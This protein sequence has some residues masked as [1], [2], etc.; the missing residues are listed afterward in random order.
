VSAS[1]NVAIL[2]A[3]G[4]VGQEMLK[5]LMTR[6]FPVKSLKLL[7]SKRSAGTTV[8]Y[9]GKTYTIE[10]ATAQSFEGVDLVLASAGASISAELAPHAVKAGAVVV[11]NTSHY[12][13]H[14]D[15]PLVVPEVNAHALKD[16][17]GIIANPNCST[18]QLVVVLDVLRQLA[19][20]KRVV[21]STYQSVSGAGKEAMEELRTQTEG[22]LKGEAPK[23]EHIKH[24]IAF[25]LVPAI[26]VFTDNG[27]T[28][29]E[30]KMT[31]ETRKI[32]GDAHFA[33][34]ATAVRVPVM[35]GH[36]EAVNVE[37]DRP[38]SP[39]AARAALEKASGVVVMDDPANHVYPR[40]META[41]TDPVYVGRIRGDV[42]HA[43]GLNLW[44]VA[45]NLRKGAALN[46]V[47]IAESLAA[48]GL[49]GRR[50]LV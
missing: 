31:N 32:L 50:A 36:S 10:E 25:N 35:V 22:A 24:P 37:F 16:H 2:G 43:N 5:T 33:L 3:T 17:Q 45:D 19:P 27:Y 11:D 39:E 14:E 41:G 28:K 6:N 47:Q 4:V 42:S 15:V 46:A 7:A 12:R 29:E 9:A 18:A 40:P 49:L 26:D 30:M 34:S 1:Y 8:E 23:P 21:V 48:Q 44:V 38:V 20:I 13:M